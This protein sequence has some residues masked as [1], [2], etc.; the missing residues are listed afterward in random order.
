MLNDDVI[1]ERSTVARG[2]LPSLSWLARMV[3]LVS[4]LII[5]VQLTNALSAR[6]DRWLILR[7][8][9]T[10]SEAPYLS[11][12]LTSKA[13]TVRF[14]FTLI[15]SRLQHLSIILASTVINV[16]LCRLVFVMPRGFSQKWLVK[17][18]AIFPKF[19]LYICMDDPCV[20]STTWENNLKSLESMFA[21]LQAAG[22]TLKP[23]KLAFGPKL[24][25][26]LGRAISAEGVAVGKYR[27]KVI[28]R[29]TY[30]H[31]H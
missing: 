13:H 9:L 10:W 11:V 6:P 16:E 17:R 14:S 31:L 28:S 12:P 18:W 30:P 8:T 20:L 3:N 1:E 4:V 26:Y 19:L 23:S 25:A 24:V 2:D 21:A 5:E 27:I 29:A 15:M 22:I 7:I